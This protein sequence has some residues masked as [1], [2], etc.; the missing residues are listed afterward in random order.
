MLDASDVRKH[1]E[2]LTNEHK[3]PS[4]SNL[5]KSCSEKQKRGQR[6]RTSPTVRMWADFVCRD[7]KRI[8]RAASD[9]RPSDRPESGDRA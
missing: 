3:E 6:F 8:L 1:T 4:A 9:F 7:G 2:R 5:S